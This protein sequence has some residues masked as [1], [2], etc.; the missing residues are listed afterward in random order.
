MKLQD[1]KGMVFG[2]WTVL[3]RDIDKSKEKKSSY[4]FCKCSCG[5]IKS[6]RSA[7]LK[8]GKSLSCGHSKYDVIADKVSKSR[9]GKNTYDMSGEYGIG[10]T[11]LGDKFI[12]D[13]EDFD[14][15][16]DYYWYI[17][18]RGYVVSSPSR[19]NNHIKMHRLI[20]GN[21]KECM[22]DHINRER[23]DNRKCN[24]RLADAKLNSHNRSVGKNNKSGYLG[25][26]KEGNKWRVEISNKYIGAYDTYEEAVEA[27]RKAELE[28]WGEIIER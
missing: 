6:V 26:S 17:D 11:I 28:H 1:L 19:N 24:L 12:F 4:W 20:M 5:E 22:I 9:K 8:R 7:D 3:E 16:K 14:L 2:E 18:V 21:P 10:Y 23:N 27:R 25:V 13:K 15:I